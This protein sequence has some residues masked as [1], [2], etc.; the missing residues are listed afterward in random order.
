MAVY[1]LEED[2]RPGQTMADPVRE[3]V[4]V[5]GLVVCQ[6]LDV[7]EASSRVQAGTESTADSWAKETDRG[8]TEAVDAEAPGMDEECP[9]EEDWVH[10][11]P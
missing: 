5:V 8:E 7:G 3:A 9:D 2:R 10:A 1:R 6:K 11:M 4:A